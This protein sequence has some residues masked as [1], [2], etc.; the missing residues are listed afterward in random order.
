[1]TSASLDT[2]IFDLGGVL[3]DWNPRYLYR[4][5]I[6][7]ENLMEDFLLRVCNH[8]WNSQLDA[9]RSFAEAVRELSSKHPDLEPLIQAYH[10][11]WDEMLGAA[12]EGTV[13][14]LENL[15]A[16]CDYRLLALTNWSAETFPV[17][18]ARYS[19]LNLF[20]GILVS[21]HEKLAKPDIRIF[22][23]LKTRYAIAPSRSVFIDDSID[24]I[25]AA[26]KIGFHS[27]QFTDPTHLRHELMGIGIRI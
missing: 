16:H 12:I 27:L 21:G 26:K 15:H 24:N 17:A 14:I 18:R 19:F 22:D 11:R 20:D 6:A 10:E 13:E 9:G 8:E 5:L 2:I 1:M 3:I 7:D 25:D 23:L 4:K